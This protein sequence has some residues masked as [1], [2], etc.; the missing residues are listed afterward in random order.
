MMVAVPLTL[1][2]LVAEPPKTG[3][4]AVYGAV[5]SAWLT[6]VSYRNKGANQILHQRANGL[7]HPY[8]GFDPISPCLNSYFSLVS[9][10]LLL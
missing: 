10:G 9:G 1:N 3:R 4:C 7:P 6:E 2:S 5:L 8:C